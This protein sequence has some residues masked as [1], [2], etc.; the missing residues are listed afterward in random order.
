MEGLATNLHFVYAEVDEMYYFCI[1]RI[2]EL[3]HTGLQAN[4]H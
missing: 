1:S 3:P 2:F 4:F